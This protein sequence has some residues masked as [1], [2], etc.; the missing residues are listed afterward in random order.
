MV[1]R[2]ASTI[3]EYLRT[4]PE[5]RRRTLADL[6][7][8]IRSIVPGA[9]EYP[10]RRYDQTKSSLH[11]SADESLPTALVRKL[12]RARINETRMRASA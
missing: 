5:D 8:K 7:I 9:E 3:D 12:I 10:L 11:L 4:V 2:K 1:R 6:R